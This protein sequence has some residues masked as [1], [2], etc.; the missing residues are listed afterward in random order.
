MEPC[1]VFERFRRLP[2][3]V[4]NCG[5]RSAAENQQPEC[6]AHS[7]YESNLYADSA[8]ADSSLATLTFTRLQP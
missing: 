7:E 8:A 4:P 5:Q 6:K 2:K 3:L 1:L